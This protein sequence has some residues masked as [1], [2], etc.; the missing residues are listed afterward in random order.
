MKVALRHRCSFSN[1]HPVIA[2]VLAFKNL[3]ISIGRVEGI[4]VSFGILSSGL[5]RQR[6]P[7]R[8]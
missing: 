2:T 3:P 4:T 6:S 7:L 5:K 8:R 1:N